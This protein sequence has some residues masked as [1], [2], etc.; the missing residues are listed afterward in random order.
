[1]KNIK[2]YESFRTKQEIADSCSKYGIKG[3]RIRDDGSIDV[4]GSVNLLKK[5]GNL[6]TLPLTFNTIG[7]SFDCY[8]NNLTTL[9]GCPKEVGGNFYCTSNNIISLKYSPEIVDG[10]FGCTDNEITSLDGLEDTHIS[11][12]LAVNDCY[13]LYSLTGYPKQVAGFECFNT[14]IK[15]IYDKFIQVSNPNIINR[16]NKHRV[17]YNDGIYWHINYNHLNMF[18]ES[19]NRDDLIMSERRFEK[20]ISKT[21]YRL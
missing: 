6:E 18:L 19:I 20:F 3:Y 16:F 5:L 4:R 1:M 9:E 11:G 15:P 8:G 14:P 12:Y 10:H 7:D 21:E 13:N 2:V 17:V